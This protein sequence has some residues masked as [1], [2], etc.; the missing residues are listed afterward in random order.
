MTAVTFEFT[1]EQREKYAGELL[2]ES[3]PFKAALI[4]FGDK[5]IGRCAFV[6]AEWPHD[7]RIIKYQQDIL[8]SKKVGEF[9]PTKEGI[10]QILDTWIKN[11]K[12]DLKDRLNSVK[13]MADISGWIAKPETTIPVNLNVTSNVMVVKEHQTTDEWEKQLKA[14]QE[15]LTTRD[16]SAAVRH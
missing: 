10:L 14:Q 16:D 1:D 11:D 4:V 12:F 7:P 6:A 2:R 9:L 13:M 8:N 3:N 15:K 5:E